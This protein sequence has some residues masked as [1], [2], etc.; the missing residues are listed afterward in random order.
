MVEIAIC[1]AIIGF[2]LVA[3][4]GIL[5]T[6][7]QVQKEN[8]Q[9]T[10]INQDATV[11]LD[12]IRNGAQGLDD[13]TNYVM[14][15]TNWVTPYKSSG[16]PSGAT[17]TNIYTYNGSSRDGAQLNP[18]FPI[19]NGFR[20]IGLLSTPKYVP[21]V[22]TNK[23]GFV[24]YYSNHV[25]AYV[26]SL[27]GPAS[28]KFPQTNESVQDLGF[29]YRLRSEVVP[30]WTNYYDTNWL[31]SSTQ[32]LTNNLHDLRLTFRWPLLDQRGKNGPG[33]QAFRTL[34]GGSLLRTNGLGYLNRP[35]YDLYFFQPRTYVKAP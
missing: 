7:M 16:A 24:G 1:L 20:I 5:P 28:E 13:L 11:F 12:A 27:S 19:T 21:S 17:V 15:I 3:I 6:G 26:R 10:V 4:I 23:G 30:C 14:G 8:R 31:S 33:Y 29:S 34:A 18:P 25:E 22:D 2:A 9:E 35:E 32:S